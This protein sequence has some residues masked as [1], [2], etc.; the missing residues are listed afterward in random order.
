MFSPR[1]TGGTNGPGGTRSDISKETTGTRPKTYAGYVNTNLQSEKKIELPI[2]EITVEKQDGYSLQRMDHE[3][4]R[5]ICDT[6]G[7]VKGRDIKGFQLHM[8]RNVTKLSL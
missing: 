4:A 7:I 1:G 3:F 6:M 5:E 2:L 8:N